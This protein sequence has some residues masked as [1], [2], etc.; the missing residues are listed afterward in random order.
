M[1]MPLVLATTMVLTMADAAKCEPASSET[2]EVLG[3]V[4]SPNFKYDAEGRIE[5]AR[6]LSA[7]C[8]AAM[9][10]IPTNTPQEQEWVEAEGNTRD[11][12]KIARLVATPEWGRYR[13]G[14]LYGDCISAT[15]KISS[16]QQNSAKRVEAAF[17]TSLSITFNDDHDMQLYAKNASVDLQRHGIYFI[18]ALR[19]GMM[20][21][22]L[23]A[24]EEVQ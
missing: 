5:F 17:W 14:M 16:A 23:R 6:A 15:A 3:I 24:I 2:R 18:R 10:S 20:I 7:Y 12:N 4:T 21:A 13:L 9:A 22:A 11:S 19:R 8:S 1:R